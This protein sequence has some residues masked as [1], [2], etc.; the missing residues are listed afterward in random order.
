MIMTS[1]SFQLVLIA[2]FIQTIILMMTYY[3]SYIREKNWEIDL[4]RKLN[5]SSL[6]DIGMKYHTDKIFNHHYET[7]YEKY[8]THYRDTSVRLLEIGLGCGMGEY[9]GASAFTWREYLGQKADIHIMELDKKCGQ[10]WQTTIGSQVTS[11]IRN[12]FPLNIK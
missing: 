10:R 2:F 7:L 5:R 9:I 11:E 1:R 6:Y 8:L 4:K 12:D 3:K